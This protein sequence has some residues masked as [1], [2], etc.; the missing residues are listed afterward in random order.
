[1]KADRP[2]TEAQGPGPE[3]DSPRGIWWRWGADPRCAGASQTERAR[4][5]TTEPVQDNLSRSLS[6]SLLR[7]ALGS[8]ANRPPPPAATVEQATKPLTDVTF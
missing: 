7:A 2:P 1:M 8:F 6:S 5:R 3:E 4:L